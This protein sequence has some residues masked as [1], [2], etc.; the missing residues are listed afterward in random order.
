MYAATTSVALVGGDV[1]AVEVQVHVGRQNETFK[2]S[3]LADTAVREAK[4]R[5]RAAV[6]SSGIQ[7]PNRTVTVNLAPAHLPKS[8]TDYDLAIALGVLAASNEIPG[9]GRAVVVGELALDGSVRSGPST[10]GAAVLS[11]RSGIPCLVGKGTAADVAAV[12]GSRVHGVGSLAEAVELLRRGLDTAPGVAPHPSDGAAEP[13][14]MSEVRGQPM[15]RRAIE[16]A[17]AGGHHLLLHGPPGGGKTMLA[18]RLNGLQPPLTD[19]EAV[20]VALIHAAAGLERGLSR[21]RPFRS[22]HHTASRM[23]LVGGGSGVAVPG[24]VSLAHRGT[25]FLDEMAE[26][27][28]GNLDTLRQPLE[29][30]KVTVARRGVT[31]T[32]PSSFHLIAATNPCPCGYLGDHRK[33][34][35]CRPAAIA[36]YRQRVSGP[37]LDRFDLVVKV[38]RLTARALGEPVESTEE[39]RRRVVAASALL[40]QRQGQLTELA[41]GHLTT[42]LK[43]GYLTARGVDKI[44]LVAGTISALAEMETIDEDHIAEAMALRASW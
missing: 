15:A 2:L 18:R 40:A 38:D 30:G 22:P 1:R 16:I 44:R 5:V 17:A 41:R 9:P 27:P 3:G 32:F 26:F 43:N 28:R 6:A 42:A 25:L 10:L 19:S 36:R 35:E 14:D 11:A 23:A 37:L 7:F 8:G 33:P 13:E 12:P 4:D 39:V 31:A 20:E 29:D 34:C 21:R 24:E